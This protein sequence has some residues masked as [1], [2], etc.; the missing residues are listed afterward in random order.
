MAAKDLPE[1]SVELKLVSSYHDGTRWV[2]LSAEDG[3][4]FDCECGASSLGSF[5]TL[6]RLIAREHGVRVVNPMYRN[7]AQWAIAKGR[8]HVR[9]RQHWN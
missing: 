6:Q 8:A 1:V 5:R 3:S 7:P 2:S 4:T 9:G